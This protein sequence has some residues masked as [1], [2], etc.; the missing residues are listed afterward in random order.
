MSAS[1]SRLF[2]LSG[3]SALITGATGALGSAAAQALAGA[4]AKVTLAGGNADALAKLHAELAASGAQ[5]ATVIGR[6]STEAEA[7]RLVEAAI[8]HGGG[9]DILISASGTAKVK[10]ALAMTPDEWDTVM[11][12]NVRQSWLIAR[13]AGQ[14]MTT[15]GRGG[16]ILFVSSV[17]G[18]FATASGTTA[19]SPSK[20]GIDMLTR[21]FA[22]EWGKFS[23]NVNAIAPT[24]FRS[25]LTAWLFEEK[26]TPERERILARIPIGRLAEPSDFAGS[27]VFLASR[28]S[29]YITGEILHVDGGFSAN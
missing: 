28:A 10:P 6:P 7:A 24:I 20:A 29:D 25:E 9:L 11:E 8:H 14:V 1:I 19:Y 21:S 15:A 17:R 13:A 27:I 26:A 16:K 3:K 12:A 22:A 23:I 5:A 4:G 18:R 2:D